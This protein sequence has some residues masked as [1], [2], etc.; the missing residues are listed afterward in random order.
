[1]R[2]EIRDPR[3]ELRSVRS[4]IRSVRDV[5]NWMLDVGCGMWDVMMCHGVRKSAKQDRPN[6]SELMDDG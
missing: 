5:G 6:E 3:S 2:S 4:E 1:M